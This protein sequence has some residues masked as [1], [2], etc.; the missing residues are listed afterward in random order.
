VNR[1]TRSRRLALILLAL[2]VFGGSAA[3]VFGGDFVRLSQQAAGESRPM[4]IDADQISTWTEGDQRIL[5]VRGQVLVQQGV[6]RAH[7]QEGVIFLDL[8]TR[9]TTRVWNADLYGEGDFD[10]QNGT[11]SSYG[12]TGFI[13]LHTSG[14]LKITAHKG[15]VAEQALRD[16]PVYLRAMVRR[17][18]QSGTPQASV[19]K[20]KPAN[21]IQ[22]VGFNTPAEPT[23][24]P[25]PAAPGA[26]PLLPPVPAAPPSQP[27]PG[28][29][30]LLPP[31]PSGGDAAVPPARGGAPPGAAAP[32]GPFAGI[33][34]GG[35]PATPGKPAPVKQ[36]SILPRS[37]SS[38]ASLQEQKSPSGEVIGYG[39]GGFYI[40]V[41][42]VDEL[43]VASD[44]VDIETDRVIVWDHDG[45]PAPAEGVKNPDE[46]SSRKLEFYLGGNVVIRQ[47]VVKT[48]VGPAGIVTTTSERVFRGDEVYYDVSRNVA[49]A[50]RGD[51]DFQQPGVPDHIHFK[52]DELEQL[53][54]TQ[55]KGLRGEFFSSR[56]PSD[57][58][59]KV[60]FT[61]ATMT[62][63]PIKR[64]GLLG[65]FGLVDDIDDTERYVDANNVTFEAADVPFFYLP[66][67]R[68][69]ANDPLGPVNNFS[70]G[71]NKVF[72]AE[73]SVGLDV[74]NLLGV[75]RPLNTRWR[76]DLEYLSARGPALG[77]TF[78]TAGRK[79]FG[80]DATYTA[81]VKLF[82][83]HDTGLDNLGGSRT[84]LEH[85]NWRYDA[86]VRAKVLDLPWGFSAQGQLVGLSDQNFY[87]QYY[88][89]LFDNALNQ[90]TYLYAK[91]Q[92]DAWAWTVLGETRL[93]NW[94]TETEWL[95]RLDGYLLGQSFFDL[96]TYNAH[97]SAGYAR[98]KVTETGPPPV[99]PTDVNTDTG[100]VDL[101]QKVSAP[102]YLG[103][104]KV[105][106]YAVLDLTAYSR[107]L[108]GDSNGRVYGGGGVNASIPFTRLYPD[109]QSL[110][111][112]LNGI[113]H[114]IVLNANFFTADAT[115]RYT[116]LPQLD[117][118]WDDATD[119]SQRDWRPVLPAYNPGNGLYLAT[120]PLFNPQLYAIRR[121]VM[122]RVDTLDRI[123][124]INLD[125]RQRWQT[126]RG[127]PG[128]QHIVDWM[129]LDLSGTIYPRPDRDNFGAITS[130]L[131]YDWMWNVG[132]RTSLV[133]SGWIDPISNG[134]KVFTVGAFFNRP[135][136]TSFYIGYREIEPVGSRAVSAA[137]TYV[138]S[139][140]YAMTASTTYDFG[141]N[142]ALSNSL[143]MTRMGSDLQLSVG[144]T[145]NALQ[146]NF[147]AFVELVPNLL[148][149]KVAPG[150][151]SGL[152]K[153]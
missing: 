63:R 114:K 74:F 140:K 59:L 112:N 5:L 54:P 55:F 64:R 153:H 96:L 92:Q 58:D 80:T 3:F 113:N 131:E 141:T 106:P 1:V 93:R 126:K 111:W 35:P 24:N 15:K 109:V 68:G 10:V 30:P 152:L 19:E 28:A 107:D 25:P 116:N 90:E 91:Q 14:D 97:A 86:E 100:R 62:E 133:S 34:G 136:R 84:D 122:D 51:V 125:L 37:T 82:G 108:N 101:M 137:V 89:P 50:I 18:Q 105:S 138:F 69:D 124:E 145:Y 71:Y 31:V 110:L 144:I 103:P 146:N 119:Q 16:D 117:R 36:F 148:A 76:M 87:E 99:V 150:V 22:T 139:P 151:G 45:E 83:I 129:T 81:Q 42:T 41:W 4:V 48:T 94:V 7:L 73:V 134:P 79:L 127:F 95:P 2:A 66:F 38:G 135:D 70:F 57:P 43:G 6:L 147:G 26:V 65:F 33:L 23:Q 27:P 44:L 21:T 13:D 149:A 47:K 72:G 29:V 12:K 49:I 77:T 128:E 120:S 78:D 40:N 9:E 130:F 52:A 88:K 61:D 75:R 17:A 53:S 115:E 85:P 118:L 104:V 67:L 143:V 32:R 98:L 46:H 60:E 121:L 8:K 11:E 39:S 56:L 123:E 132:D 142:Q 102:F 20:P